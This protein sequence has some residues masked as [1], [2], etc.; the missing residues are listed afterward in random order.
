MNLEL[1]NEY[2]QKLGLI[3]EAFV[4]DKIDVEE[5]EIELQRLDDWYKEQSDAIISK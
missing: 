5:Y 1:E 3:M 4:E 2:A